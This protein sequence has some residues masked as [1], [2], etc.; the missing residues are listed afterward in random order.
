MVPTLSLSHLTLRRLL[1]GDLHV[2]WQPSTAGIDRKYSN[3]NTLR[4]EKHLRV[5]IFFFRINALFVIKVR[6]RRRD[7]IINIC[8]EA[9]SKRSYKV[10]VM[11]RDE[12]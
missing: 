5:Q 2:V 12:I 7:H 11:W 3:T 8:E 9:N 10:Y 1:A 6:K 4:L